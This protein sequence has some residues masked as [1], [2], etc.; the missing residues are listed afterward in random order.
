MAEQGMLQPI[1]ERKV[2]NL[3]Y[4]DPSFLTYASPSIQNLGYP[5]LISYSGVAYRQ[6]KVKEIKHSWDVFG[7]NNYKGRMTM[8]NDSRETLG[9][10]LRYLGFSINT[11]N[12]DE[13]N[14]AAQQIIQWKKNLAKFESEQYKNGIASGEYL[15][16]HGYNGDILQVMQENPHVQFFLPEEGSVISIDYMVIPKNAGNTKLAQEFMD[17][18]LEPEVAAENMAYTFFLCPNLGAY[19]HLPDEMKN[20]PALFPPKE[21]MD[22]SEVIKNLGKETEI[23]NKAWD[24]VKST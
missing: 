2:P 13:I 5:Y 11:T 20:N 4:L 12:S 19:E 7:S 16:A 9:A 18:L 23:Y 6:D 3:K 10:A 21:I 17:Y 14:K 1:D 8:L 22:K 15:V 24:A